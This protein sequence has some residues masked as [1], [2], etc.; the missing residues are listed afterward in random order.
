[1]IIIAVQFCYL[2]GCVYEEDDDADSVD[3]HQIPDGSP[4]FL[5]LYWRSRLSHPGS[6]PGYRALTQ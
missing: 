5:L 4:T 1:M 3:R 6:D 2:H